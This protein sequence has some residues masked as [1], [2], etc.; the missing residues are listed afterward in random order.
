MENL[1]AALFEILSFGSIVVLVVLGLGIIASM[2]GIFNFAQGEFVLLGAYVTYLA[3]TAGLPV[4]TGMVAAPF[5][6]G[7]FGL[8]LERLIVRRFYA[9]PIVAMLG[10][11]ALGLIIREI[12]R[13]LI[14]GL[15]ISVPEPV[16]GSIT[17]GDMHL[18]TWRLVIVI[19]T[20]LVMIGSYLLLSRTSFGLRVRASLENP[21]LARAS[22][23]STNAIYGA[24]FAFGAALAGL[25]GALIVPV[26]SL[27]AD[28][29][30]RFL[31]QGFIAVMVGGVGSFAGPVAGAGI[32]GTLSAALPWVIQPVIADVLVFVLA[33]IFIKFRPQG[34]VSGKGI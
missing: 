30:L 19:V 18:S 8:V 7:A 22:G 4:W 14:G 26:F 21:A 13:G 3:H 23:I 20:A 1:F 9:A 6:V 25:A 11:Y 2:M 12:V 17:I 5:M 27:F 31:I 28:L 34:L 24:T 32:I 10:T 33:I 15:Y 16:G 29:G